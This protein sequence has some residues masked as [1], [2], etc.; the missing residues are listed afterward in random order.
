MNHI[1]SNTEM[2]HVYW[3]YAINPFDTNIL[4]LMKIGMNWVETYI[5]VR[6]KTTQEMKFSIKYFFSKYDQICG[7]L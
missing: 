7:K 4:F 6:I 1:S 5:I 3:G 2:C